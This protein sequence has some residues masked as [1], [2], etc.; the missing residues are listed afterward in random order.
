[1]LCSIFIKQNGIFIFQIVTPPS[2]GKYI[3][4]KTTTVKKQSSFLCQ[5]IE[6]EFASFDRS[7][8]SFFDAAKKKKWRCQIEKNVNNAIKWSKKHHL[9]K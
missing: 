2:S 6:N 3:K 9:S 1:M 4:T 8:E 5:M 7:I